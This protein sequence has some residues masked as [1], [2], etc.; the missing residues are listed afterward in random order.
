ME[1]CYFAP[2]SRM[3]RYDLTKLFRHIKCHRILNIFDLSPQRQQLFSN[4]LD[5]EM[6][7]IRRMRKQCSTRCPVL[8]INIS[9]MSK[10]EFIFI[11]EVPG[12]WS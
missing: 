12:N 2:I 7:S 11:F 4:S 6:Y 9:Q 5:L 10:S 1:F 8:L 3:S